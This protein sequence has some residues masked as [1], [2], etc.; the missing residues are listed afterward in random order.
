VAV[1]HEAIAKPLFEQ[2]VAFLTDEIAAR[3]KI[4]LH[5]KDWPVLDV[6]IQHTRPLRLRFRCD[7][8]SELPPSIAMLNPDGSPFSG[9]LPGGIFHPEKF[10]CMRGSLEYHKH[11]SHQ[12]DH[13]ATYRNQDGM[14]II[15]ILMQIKDAW[16]MH[17]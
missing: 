11:P 8:W 15:G 7:S 1:A 6:T 13:W 4:S 10:I 3:M 17:P 16:R 5:S 14:N 9:N 2:D 12:N